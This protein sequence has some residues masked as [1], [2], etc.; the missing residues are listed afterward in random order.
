MAEL[1]RVIMRKENV[2]RRICVSGG[3]AKMGSNAT[4][5]LGD[6]ATRFKRTRI[7]GEEAADPVAILDPRL[8]ARWRDALD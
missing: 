8:G 7:P 1:K 3:G 4:T 5:P 2:T 6:D